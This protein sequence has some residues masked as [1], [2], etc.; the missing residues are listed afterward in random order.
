MP[1]KTDKLKL[2]SPF[3]DRRTKMLPCQKERAYAMHHTDGIPIRVIARSFNVDK[4]TIQFL[5]YPERHERNLEL[6]DARGGSA[7]YYV[8]DDNTRSMREH[9]RY[10]HKVLS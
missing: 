3:L 8:R 6:R 10:K 1:Y 7:V 9:R 2:D 4:R 5:C